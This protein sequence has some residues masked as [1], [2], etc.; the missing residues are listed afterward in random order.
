MPLKDDTLFKV[1]G[2]SKKDLLA[3]VI[4][5]MVCIS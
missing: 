3:N 5:L 4:T 1:Q 2:T